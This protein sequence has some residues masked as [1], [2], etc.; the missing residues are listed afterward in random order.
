MEMTT[1]AKKL[2][3]AS[4]CPECSVIL[5]SWLGRSDWF[6]YGGLSSRIWLAHSLGE[7]VLDLDGWKTFRLSEIMRSIGPGV[8]N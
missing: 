7:W 4:L 2:A 6:W 1:F 8:Q 5:R 3:G